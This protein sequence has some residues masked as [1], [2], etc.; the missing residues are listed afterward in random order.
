MKD[1]LEDFAYR[2]DIDVFIFIISAGI[3]FLVA[4]I[5]VSYQA[6]RAASAN[7]INSI[8]YE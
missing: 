7:P 4:L 3:A 1:W 2:I 6:L 8:K 5:A